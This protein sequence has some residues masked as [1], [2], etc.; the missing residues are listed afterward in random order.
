ME[1]RNLPSAF[2]AV[3]EKFGSKKDVLRYKKAGKYAGI[4]Y[5]ELRDLVESFAV[6]LLS[7]G[8]KK[9]DRVGIA[10][11]NRVKWI[12]ADLG[13]LSVGAIDVPVFPTL[14]AKQEEY[15]FN[16]CEASVIVV[17]NDLQLKKILEVRDNLP[18]LR[19]IIVM[20]NKFSSDDVSIYSMDDI[21]K[22]GEKLKSR[23]ERRK[24]VSDIVAKIDAESLATIIY[25]SGTTGDPKG[26][27]LTHKNILSNI[28]GIKEVIKMDENDTFLSFLPMCHSYE[29]TTGYYTAL[30]TGGTI[31]L[32]ESLETVATNLKEVKPTLM[33]TVPRL[34]EIVMKKVYANVEKEG[35]LKKKIFDWAVAIGKECWRKRIKG[36]PIP[37][38]LIAKRKIADKL[39]YSKI[40]ARFG[41]RTRFFISGGAA[42]RDDVA[43]FFLS[44]NIIVLE[45]YGLTEAAPVVAV[46]R[47]D[48]IEIGSIGE[49]LNNVEVKIADDGELLVR[50][51]NVMKGYWNDP[52]ATRAAIDEDGWLYTG[53]IAEF[54]EKGNLKI[55]D[56][57]KDLIVSSG[58]KNIA[59]QPIERLLSKSPYIERCVIIGDKR[60]F[61]SALISPDFEE[62]KK[63]ADNFEIKYEKP[64]DLITNDKI[65]KTIKDDI[66]RLQ[67][68]LAKYERVRKFS[69]VSEPF[70]VENGIL[71]PKLSV[72]RHIVERKFADLID[73]M[74][75]FDK[76]K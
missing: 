68:D 16:H 44:M 42:L 10:S 25:T 26:V 47:P 71:T 58:G 41:G 53:D 70:S 14:T 31:A 28:E 7:L 34:L 39:V 38:S 6:G 66:D 11:E 61:C 73:S 24:T 56:R 3:C 18:S 13:I 21:I 43:E 57:K 35:G 60:E 20:N 37:Y 8:V 15:I 4:N 52:D 74:Y 65:I 48:N 12:I 64:S 5:D 62:L 54:T 9:G 36:E 27:E 45:G 33:T 2:Y 69:L 29:R 23:E 49:P 19:H 67:K 32:A 63:L 17:S 59:P 30:F 46:N 1:Y 40:K 51:P 75:G 76:S 50:G 55:T 72:R 22:R